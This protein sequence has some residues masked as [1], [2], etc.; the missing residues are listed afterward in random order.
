MLMDVDLEIKPFDEN[1]EFHAIRIRRYD[2]QLEDC[3]IATLAQ[4]EEIE[5]DLTK[6]V[7]QLYAY[8]NSMK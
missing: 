4:I 7:M 1:K 6:K 5:I 2:E 8:R 3:I